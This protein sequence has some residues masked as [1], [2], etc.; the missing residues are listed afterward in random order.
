MMEKTSREKSY[1]DKDGEALELDDAWFAAAARGRPKLLS[2]FFLQRITILFDSG[3]ISHFKS[4]GRLW[5][6][7]IN[8]S[9][10][11]VAGP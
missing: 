2:D 1:I 5:Q 11:Q 4:D 8:K 6:T 7:R 9:F 10:R 3:V